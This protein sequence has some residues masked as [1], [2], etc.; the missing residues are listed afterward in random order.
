MVCAA[1][2]SRQSRS[3]FGTHIV[4]GKRAGYSLHA[5]L[6]PTNDSDTYRRLGDRR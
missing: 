1:V 6:V 5:R 4:D 3:G 2:E